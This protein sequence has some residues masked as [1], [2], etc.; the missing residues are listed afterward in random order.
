MKGREGGELLFY[1][2]NAGILR[3][4]DLYAKSA[5][6]SSVN[7]ALH[8]D[9]DKPQS[10]NEQLMQRQFQGRNQAG[11]QSGNAVPV[12]E[13]TVQFNKNCL[14]IAGRREISVQQHRA[15]M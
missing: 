8:S 6:I 2:L 1:G 14:H 15:Q 13:L 5:E 9:N 11:N 10:K 4:Q 12:W 3:C 7:V